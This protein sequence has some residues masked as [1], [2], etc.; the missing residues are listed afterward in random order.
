MTEAEAFHLQLPSKTFVSVSLPRWMSLRFLILLVLSANVVFSG[1]IVKYLPGFDGELPFKLETGYISGG[2]ELFYYFIESKGTLKKTLFFF[3]IV[4]LKSE[5]KSVMRS[6]QF[7]IDTYTGGLPR[8]LSYPYAWTKWLDQHPQYLP[9]QLFIGGDSYSGISVPLVTKLVV[10]GI[11]AKLKPMM[12]L[13]VSIPAQ[14]FLGCLLPSLSPELVLRF[15]LPSVFVVMA[16]QILDVDDLSSKISSLGWDEFHTLLTPVALDDNPNT[17]A[18][19]GKILANRIFSSTVVT[20][21]LTT[22]WTFVKEFSTVELEPNLFLFR[23]AKPEHQMKVLAQTPWNIHGQLMVFKPWSQELTIPKID[24]HSEAMWIHVHG[25]PWNRLGECT[26]QLIGLKLGRLLEI[27]KLEYRVHDRSPFLRLRVEPNL[28][29]PLV[30]GFPIP[31]KQFQ[32]L[33]VQFIKF[34]CSARV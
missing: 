25:L 28:R 31:R 18:V 11:A 13:K 21:S 22:A 15:S 23:F 4:K 24:F 10:D 5:G 30:G 3:G 17:P 14:C 7:D 2:F 27:D 16:S 20:A 19:I 12:N 26:V 33:W 9:V 1:S 29:H 32:P 6:M 8:L 34:K